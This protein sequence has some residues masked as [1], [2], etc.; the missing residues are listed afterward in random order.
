MRRPK[1]FL[2]NETRHVFRK[3]NWNVLLTFLDVKN[4]NMLKDIDDSALQKN[5]VL[6]YKTPQF[7]SPLKT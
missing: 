1:S 4:K 7:F 6:C 2:A 3:K 5:S